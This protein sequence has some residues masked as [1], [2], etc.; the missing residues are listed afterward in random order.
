[1]FCRQQVAELAQNADRFRNKHTD[2]IVIGSG[3][4]EHFEAFREQTGYDGLL[5]TDPLL[6]AFS[7]LG[8]T[9][10]IMGFMSIKSVF[11]AASALKKG[12][13]QGSIQGNTMQL[14][15]AV[16]VDVSGIV[17]YFYAG[18]KAGDHPA[19]DEMISALD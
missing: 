3:E 8:F 4:P 5:F 7:I 16:I 1:M 11:K 17:K 9:N 2:L 6:N 12:H 10:S 19:I 15:G 13:R 18:S 14:G